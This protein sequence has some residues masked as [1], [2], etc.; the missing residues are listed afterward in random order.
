MKKFNLIGIAIGTLIGMLYRL[1]VSIKYVHKY[2]IDINILNLFKKYIVNII[3][4]F[5]FVTVVKMMKIPDIL[6]YFEWIK[7]AIIYSIIF[8]TLLLVTN[9]LFFKRDMK[10]IYYTYFKYLISKIKRMKKSDEKDRK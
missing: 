6:T 9:I 2:L 7:Y 4:V 8:L 1:I 10:D 3:V 5:V